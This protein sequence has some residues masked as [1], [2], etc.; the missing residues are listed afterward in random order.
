MDNYWRVGPFQGLENH[1]NF[2]TLF[3]N[4][5]D[6]KTTKKPVSTTAPLTTTARQTTTKKPACTAGKRWC[7]VRLPK[8]IRP[9]HYDLKLISDVDKLKYEGIQA[10]NITV[11]S[12]IDVVLV[13]IKEKVI[14]EVVLESSQGRL[15]HGIFYQQ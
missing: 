12:P 10:I 15:S 4:K 9:T 6:S 11:S 8:E 1:N 2:S 14:T 7:D 13:H 5:G 3:G